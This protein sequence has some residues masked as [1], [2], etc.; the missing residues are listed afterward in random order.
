MWLAFYQAELMMTSYSQSTGGVGPLRRILWTFL[1]S[2]FFVIA[3]VGI[4]L[5]AIPT[6]GPLIF[7]SFALS[8]G[9]PVW[10]D[11]LLALPLMARYRGY[12]T[13]EKEFTRSVRVG[14]LG[15]MWLSI[16][17]SCGFLSLSSSGA[18]I[19]VPACLVGGICGTFCICLYRGRAS[20]S[21]DVP[22]GSTWGVSSRSAAA[23]H[24]QALNQPAA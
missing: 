17:I 21:T 18:Q 9:N 5:P 13:G 23:E 1:G 22:R 16:L 6:T 15:A 11:K 10:C 20:W 12:V 14:A 24:S 2:I 19:G 3:V 8:K 4:Y 7:A